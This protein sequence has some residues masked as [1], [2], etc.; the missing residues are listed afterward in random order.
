[1]GWDFDTSVRE[2]LAPGLR[3]RV[4]HAPIAV[5]HPGLMHLPVE[6]LVQGEAVGNFSRSEF[7]A[8][9]YQKRHVTVG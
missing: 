3:N 7:G 5:I 6:A 4:V 9:G 2:C 8:D 1:M